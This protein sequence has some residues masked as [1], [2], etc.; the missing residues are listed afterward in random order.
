[1]MELLDRLAAY[2]LN[3]RSALPTGFHLASV[4]WMEPGTVGPK[5]R[6]VHS[7]GWIVA[8]EGLVLIYP[9]MED[10]IHP[11]NERATRHIAKDRVLRITP[12]VPG[13]T[14]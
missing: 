1:M 9:D 10:G 14:Q 5:T 3:R 11:V 7:A 13:V 6:V 8:T 4:E 12:L 2:W